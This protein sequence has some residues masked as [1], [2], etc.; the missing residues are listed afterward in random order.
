MRII[1]AFIY[2]RIAH[3]PSL[4]KIVE[5]VSWLFADKILRMGAG[6]FVGVWVARY[7]GPDQFG[8]LN[9]AAALVGMFGVIGGMGL[10]GVV[11]RDIVQAPSEAG[12][13]LGT[14]AVLQL[15]GGLVAYGLML[16]TVIWLQPDVH[17][18]KALVAILGLAVVFNVGEVATYWFQA[19]VE[20]KY[21]VWVQ[22]GV[23]ALFVFVKVL[24]IL[25]NAPVVA[26]AW[27]TSAEAML[28]SVLMLLVLN[29]RGYKLQQMQVT[30]ARSMILAKEGWPLILSSLAI[31]V[32][33][34]IDQVMLGQMVGDE[35]VG[36]Y[37][38][39]VRL[40]EV[41][42]FIPMAIVASVFPA[43]LA[44]K[45]QGEA[46]YYKK[47]QDLYDGLVWLA[48]LVAIPM[49][50][51][52][53]W[54]VTIFFGHQYAAAGPVLAIHVWAAIFVFL[55]VASGQWFIA[56]KR[57]I[58]SL[59]RT[60]LGAV[61]NV[62]LNLL[63][64]PDFGPVGAATATVI[65]QATASWLFDVIQPVTRRMFVMKAKSLNPVRYAKMIKDKA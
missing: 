9:Y 60:G 38:A 29:L 5:N 55:G 41:W 53:G 27:V 48:I 14:A 16:V 49:T 8:L 18:A 23:F 31:M 6:L 37:S 34:K 63:L 22:N 20:S 43:I 10:Q 1:P 45:Q 51:L 44:V 13:T 33:M 58:L 4:V 50:F 19:Q 25:Q 21:V 64:I 59:Q 15:M 32:Y 47:L 62:G 30:L 39:A 61:V 28:V 57:Q 65:S 42:Y 56:E 24:L 52:S 54:V 3:R 35:A 2:R 36:V 17:L 40:S 7:L 26:F 12:E 46:V 11:V